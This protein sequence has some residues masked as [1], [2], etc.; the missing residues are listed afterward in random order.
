MDA[1]GKEGTYATNN[2]KILVREA[3]INAET[4]KF[5]VG[6]TNSVLTTVQAGVDDTSS[7]KASFDNKLQET[8]ANATEK[9]E[10][11]FTKAIDEL[12][13]RLLDASSA[14]S[15]EWGPWREVVIAYAKAS[16]IAQGGSVTSVGTWHGDGASNRHYVQIDYVDSAQ[17]NQTVFY[18]HVGLNDNDTWNKNAVTGR[19][20]IIE[21]NPIVDENNNFEYDKD[22]YVKFKAFEG[23]TTEAEGNTSKG[24]EVVRLS[25]K[26]N[27]FI[28]DVID[29]LNE[30]R[31]NYLNTPET[32]G[33]ENDGTTPGAGGSENN[34]GTTPAAEGNENGSGET[35]AAEGNE[36]GSGE[37]PAA[38]GD[39]TGSGETPAAEGDETGGGT[40]P[41][42][43]GEEA[44][45]GATPAAEDAT[46][47]TT[48]P[49][50]A[51]PQAPAATIDNTGSTS[52]QET[53]ATETAQ[54]TAAEENQ[55]TQTT[56]TANEQTTNASTQTQTANTVTENTEQAPAAQ[57]SRPTVEI[58]GDKVPLTVG[59]EK[60]DG[61]DVV[62]IGE[63]EV[64]KAAMVGAAEAPAAAGGLWSWILGVIAFITGK[65]ANDKKN[66]KGAFK[67]DDKK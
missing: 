44:G 6:N 4:G 52:E 56:Q 14:K 31:Q 23:A 47:G 60:E 15:T 37:T 33:N 11:E 63:K 36:N 58:G 48:I 26:T 59:L 62:N 38:E 22:N 54:T 1:D 10:D 3:G 35:P 16:I 17:K 7:L 28:Q 5:E 64:A 27:E 25:T 8:K 29:K 32:G 55:A 66:D 39:E 65:T 30:A 51:I 19:H 45:G 13:L 43:G 42:A 9:E 49:D 50:A 34:D 57:A 41:A 18:D 61:P 46:P 67:K 21:K 24:R 53:P 20:V 40:T 2:I 12:N